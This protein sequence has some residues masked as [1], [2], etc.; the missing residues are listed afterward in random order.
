VKIR[1]ID[2][3]FAKD[4]KMKCRRD[5][6]NG[7]RITKKWRSTETDE[8]YFVNFR[9]RA[10]DTKLW[11]LIGVIRVFAPRSRQSFIDISRP[12]WACVTNDYKT[13]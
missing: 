1:I 8:W 10:I 11:W 6:Q 5:I 13:K 4:F 12:N 9:N 3:E 7:G 2:H